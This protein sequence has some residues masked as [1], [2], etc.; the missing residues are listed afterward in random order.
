MHRGQ[1]KS[2][3]APK[4]NQ[5]APTEGEEYTTWMQNFDLHPNHV[6]FALGRCILKPFRS[7]FR[8]ILASVYMVIVRICSPFMLPVWLW[9]SGVVENSKDN[10]KHTVGCGE[11]GATPLMPRVPGAAASRPGMKRTQTRTM[12]IYTEANINW[13]KWHEAAS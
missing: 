6:L 4:R 9:G 10:R 5:N 11:A 3:K 13:K 1:D 8:F 7:I 12:T 2:E